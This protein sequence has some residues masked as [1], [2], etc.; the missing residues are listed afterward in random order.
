M[1]T[2][3]PTYIECTQQKK[4]A[5]REMICI[6][7]MLAYLTT[8]GSAH[9]HRIDWSNASSFSQV[10]A[11]AEVFQHSSIVVTVMVKLVQKSMADAA[12]IFAKSVLQP[13]LL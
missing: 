6:A 8:T 11:D 12:K 4:P 7:C 9:Q 13:A 2:P 3:I 10:L 1:A 5:V